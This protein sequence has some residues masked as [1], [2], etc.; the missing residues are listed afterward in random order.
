MYKKLIATAI[1]LLIS[2]SNFGA[3]QSWD[4]NSNKQAFSNT[5]PTYKL[6]S[7]SKDDNYK[8]LMSIVMIGKKVEIPSMMTPLYKHKGLTG[9]VLISQ[10]TTNITV[11]I[12]DN[13]GNAVKTIL[14]GTAQAAGLIDF[15]WDG[16]FPDGTRAQLDLY[17]IS[18]NGSV[19]GNMVALP[20]AGDFKVKSVSVNPKG[21][22]I[23]NLDR[24]GSQS[25]DD[26]IKIL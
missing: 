1:S 10:A 8:L 9:S 2:T 3:T 18:A 5:F 13:Q 14:L 16:K 19:N 12:K 20:T 7:L 26:I 4:A 21:V 17:S 23:L 22:V 25:L 11:T 15:I 6:S 24:V